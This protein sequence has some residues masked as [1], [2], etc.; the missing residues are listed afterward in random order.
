MLIISLQAFRA[1]H[2]LKMAKLVE[3]CKVHKISD[4]NNK[5]VVADGLLMYTSCIITTGR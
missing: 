2:Y 1:S 5:F 3:K 4:D